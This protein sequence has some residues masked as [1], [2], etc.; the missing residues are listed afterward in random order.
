MRKRALLCFLLC[1]VLFFVSVMRVTTVATTDF[2]KVTSTQNGIRLKIGYSRGTIYDCHN[3]WLTN[4][5]EK[6][7]AAVSP[8]P[9][10]VMKISKVLEGEQLAEVLERLKSGKPTLCEVPEK[11]QW[12]GIICT[13]VYDDQDTSSNHIIGYTNTDK[14]GVS[15]LEKAYD[16]LLYCEEEISV[17]YNTDA[18]GRI[19]EGIEPELKN[20][21]HALTH[22]VKTTLDINIQ[23]IAEKNALHLEQG[24]VIV[25]DAKT[26]KIRASVSRP[27]FDKNNIDI[28]LE[29][30]NSPLLNRTV[31]AYNV[32]SVFKP[33]VAVAG[34]E[35]RLNS[36]SYECTGSC[37][38]IDRF[39]KCHKLSGHG[40]LDL[41]GGLAQSCNTYFYNFAFNIGGDKILNTA[42]KLSFGQSLK[43]CEGIYTAKGNLPQNAT[44]KN[45]AHLANF[46]IGQGELLL[47]PV[48]ML[49]LY[50]AI[51]SGGEY[52][53]PSIVEGIIENGSIKNYD[54]GAKTKAFEAETA[55]LLKEYLKAV[56]EEGTGQSGKPENVSAAGKTATAQTGKFRDGKEISESWFCGFFPAEEPRYVV[57]VFSEDD[58]KQTLTCSEIFKN[59]A[60]EISVLKK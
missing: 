46:S 17:F 45:I 24:A 58:T 51:A 19:L 14:R 49:T 30:E 52:Y 16:S 53:I 42:R 59:I 18:K 13:S 2:S 15:G 54:I 12:D 3:V 9:S 25:A 56:L 55:D 6:I 31:N 23:E 34:I 57:I 37:E 21:K 40:A 29:S 5:R 41:K 60:D 33:C 35:S 11:F 36:F 10:A 26:A 43:I 32:G 27:A 44:L 1:M 20:P 7:I 50:C 8:T 39:F 28:Y 22:G 48:S 4:S 47:S 38:I